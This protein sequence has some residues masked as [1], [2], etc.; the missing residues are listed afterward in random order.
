TVLQRA[1][2]TGAVISGISKAVR[3]GV[4]GLIMGLGAYLV[5][6]QDLTPGG[7]IAASIILGRALAPVEQLIGTWRTLVSARAANRRITAILN[8]DAGRTDQLLLPPPR[9]EITARGLRYELRGLPR[10]IING[11]SIDLNP[12][13]VTGV[14]GPSG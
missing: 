10:P 4:Q 2:T 9:G 13:A 12:G 14:I 3:L 7:M 6:V 11:V 1:V 5:V 8:A